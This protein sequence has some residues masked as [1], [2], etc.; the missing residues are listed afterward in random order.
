MDLPTLWYL[1]IGTL[2]IGAAMT[3]W[4]RQAHGHR[5]RQLGIWAASY[6]VFAIGCVLAMNRREFPGP[7]GWALTNLVMVVGYTMVWHG[8]ARLDGPVRALRYR[9]ALIV[10]LV[11]LGWAI[12]GAAYTDILWNHVSAFPI[13]LI[14]G[15]TAWT[16]WH[17]GTV[18]HLR[19]RPVAVAVFACHSLF[20]VLRIVVSP[21]LVA[22]YG[23]RLLPIFAK[24]TMYEAVLYSMAMPM[25]F[26]ALIREEYQ[27][28]L[29]TASRTDFLT[30]LGNRQGFFEQGTKIL[31]RRGAD[32]PVSLLA[33]DLDHFKAINDRYGHGVGDEVLKLFAGV[34][35]DMAGPDG[36]VARLGG[37]E[38]VILLP[39]LGCKA[40]RQLGEAVSARFTAEAARQ[41]GPG[42]EVTLSVGVAE[43]KPDRNDLPALLSAADRALYQ[44]KALGRNRV[45]IAGSAGVVAAA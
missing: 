5:S 13:A 11:V 42:I 7:A 44:A 22:A 29:L 18:R 16:L 24:A 8:A 12:A 21:I 38:F 45:E 26:L 1:T 35:R 33:I 9:Y 41:D 14:S 31:L 2:L 36:I 30:G 19:S 43:T 4:E 39:G 32:R 6:L 28:Q 23:E 20:Y 17:S 25:A 27:A 34:A 10:A 15:L 3:L 37:E 40:A